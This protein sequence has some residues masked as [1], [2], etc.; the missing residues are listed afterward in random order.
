MTI[1]REGIFNWL[2]V[3]SDTI[4]ANKDYLT[5]L[6]AAIGDADHGANILRGFQIVLTQLPLVADK[7]IG[8]VLK[9]VGLTI[10]SSMGGAGGPLYGTFFIQMG[11][12]TLGK[13]ELTTTDWSAALEAGAKGVI[14]RGQANPGDKTMVD[15]LL[16]AATAYKEAIESGADM[17]TALFTSAQAAETGMQATI[18]LIARKG[19]AS[20]LGARSVGHQDPGATSAYLLIK[21][22]A[23]CLCDVLLAKP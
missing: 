20:Y 7:D 23:E 16:P 11:S 5:E 13:L 19:R 8:S 14:T 22:A 6:D 15:T 9:Q 10:V 1:S 21:T 3:Y 18:P 2:K 17:K 4:I 12:V